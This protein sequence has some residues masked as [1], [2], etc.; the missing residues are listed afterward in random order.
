MGRLQCK[1]I[2]NNLNTNM[3]T[4]EPSGPTEGRSE[5][6]NQTKQ[7]KTTLNIIL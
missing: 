1:N 7:K 4:P 6:S 2:F 3:V 5:H